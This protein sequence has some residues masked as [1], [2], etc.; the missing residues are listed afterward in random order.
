[1]IRRTIMTNVIRN[2]RGVTLVEL[3]AVVVILGII[4]AIAIPTIGGLIER[5]RKNAAEASFV[6]IVEASR[7]YAVAESPTGGNFTLE[8]LIT[9]GYITNLDLDVTGGDASDILINVDG[10]TVLITFGGTATV[11]KL[12][13]R[14]INI[15]TGK[16]E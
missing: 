1:M 11:L 16:A 10:S 3:L 6:T 2:R 4:A 7:L 9:D 13:D 12:N 8:D 15:S 14:V 5:Q